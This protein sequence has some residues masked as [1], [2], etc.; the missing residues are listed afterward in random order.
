MFQ[1]R[2]IVS[3]PL[4]TQYNA[5]IVIAMI[6]ANDK[7]LLFILWLLFTLEDSVLMTKIQFILKN[8]K[9][10]HFFYI[11]HNIVFTSEN[12]GPEHI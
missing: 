5:I 10:R 1:C 2:I 8:T 4:R 12:Q 3:G 9:Q 11:S 7:I 6:M